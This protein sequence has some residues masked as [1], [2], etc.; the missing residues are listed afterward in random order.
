VS[1]LTGTLGLKARHLGRKLGLNRLF[2]KLLVSGGYEARYSAA[3]AR[4]IRKGDN[5]WDV[6][7]NVGYYALS[8]SDQVGRSGRVF[9]FEPS[10]R[11]LACLHQRTIAA[12]NVVVLPLALSDTS[13]RMCFR[14]ES[15]GTTS[16]ISSN[17]S[18]SDSNETITVNARTGDEVILRGQAAFPNIIK[19]DVEGHE[20]EVVLGLSAALRD[21]RLR[22]VFVEVHFAILQERGMPAAPRRIEQTLIA[23]GFRLSWTDPSHMQAVRSC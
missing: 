13:G 16:H 22:C 7:A 3:I 19:I 14:E 1:V 20:L 23:E 11:N 12:K 6:G 2:A 4:C 10:P 21:P 18:L 15:D 9:A 17:A 8:F 5:V